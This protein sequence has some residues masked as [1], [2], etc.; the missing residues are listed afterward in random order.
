MAL[1]QTEQIIDV[2]PEERQC[3]WR[4]CLRTSKEGKFARVRV[5][6]N[7]RGLTDKCAH[8][9]AYWLRSE[10]EGIRRAGFVISI[11]S[12][13]I[14]HNELTNRGAEVMLNEVI[15]LCPHVRVLKLYRN[16]LTSA[17]KLITILKLGQLE[18]LHLSHNCLDV[19]ATTK[20]IVTAAM[21]RSSDGS[22]LYPRCG[23]PLWLRLEGNV[24]AAGVAFGRIPQSRICVV[25]GSTT[26]T[27][28]FCGCLRR[29]PAIHLTYVSLKPKGCV[30]P[31]MC[32]KDT[33]ARAIT[34]PRAEPERPCFVFT[35]DDFPALGTCAAKK[36]S[37]KIKKPSTPAKSQRPDH[38]LDQ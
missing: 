31:S 13:D 12:V 5:N 18:E 29:P 10:C 36:T 23:R 14:S 8:G 2:I 21:G 33:A 25:D 38:Q 11:V 3:E 35:A 24:G 20:I 37:T 28:A 16:C 6:M 7:N 9:W 26:C 4:Y 1:W 32:I 27:P 22:Y 34:A 15:R 17:D 19:D 30:S